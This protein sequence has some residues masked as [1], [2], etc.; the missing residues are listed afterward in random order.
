MDE[1]AN[2]LFMVLIL[3]FHL[4][5]SISGVTIKFEGRAKTQWYVYNA[6]SKTNDK[7]Y[8]KEI[9]FKEKKLILGKGKYTL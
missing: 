4:F 5:L 9:Y 7:Y 3:L 8:A 6:G 2:L 1:N